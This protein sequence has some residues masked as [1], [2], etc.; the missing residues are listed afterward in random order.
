MEDTAL[1]ADGAPCL[2]PAGHT[3]DGMDLFSVEQLL[4]AAGTSIDEPMLLPAAVHHSDDPYALS[5]EHV[6]NT[7][8]FGLEVFLRIE[9]VNTK[10]MTGALDKIYYR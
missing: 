10:P 2:I 3:K 1:P 9:Y 4:L 6:T 5:A 7:R 8:D